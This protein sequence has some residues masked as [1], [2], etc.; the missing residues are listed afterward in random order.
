MRVH[1]LHR[2]ILDTKIIREEG[3]PPPPTVRPMQH[4]GPPE[5]T[6]CQAPC[7]ST[8]CQG[9]GAEEVADLGGGDEGE[10]R[11]GLLGIQGAATKCLDI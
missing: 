11:A 2:N 6:E 1:F 3:T 5:G 10:F 8:V 7:H 9:S 4:A